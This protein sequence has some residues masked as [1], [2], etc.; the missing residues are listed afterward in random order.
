MM[1]TFCTPLGKIRA[2]A[3]CAW[4]R[5]KVRRPMLV[6]IGSVG[7]VVYSCKSAHTGAISSRNMQANKNAHRNGQ[8][9]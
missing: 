6:K 2:A 4:P 5:A 7:R 8:C 9:H 1:H 3:G